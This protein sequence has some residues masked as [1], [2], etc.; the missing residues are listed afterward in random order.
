[1]L[2]IARPLASP[3]GTLLVA[4]QTGDR[5]LELDVEGAILRRH[6]VEGAQSLWYKGGFCAAP[7]G[8]VALFAPIGSDSTFGI[9]DT[10][11]AIAGRKAFLLVLNDW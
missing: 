10:P 2:G 4:S 9:L 7:D 11:L 8:R 5:V 1:M 6:T 3:E